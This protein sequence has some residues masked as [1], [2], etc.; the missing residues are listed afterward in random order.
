MTRP[1]D[2]IAPDQPDDELM[3]EL[4]LDELV[5]AGW[6]VGEAEDLLDHHDGLHDDSPVSSC[7]ACHHGDGG[8]WS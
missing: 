5:A 6:T 8:T 1:A 4:P 7:P 3:A 2:D